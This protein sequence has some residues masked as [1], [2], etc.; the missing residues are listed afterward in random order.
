MPRG[1]KGSGKPKDP[2]EDLTTDF[3]DA[4]A[5][6]SREEIER[7]IVKVV[8]DDVDLRKAKKDDQ[9]L[10][11][12]QEAF[13]EA[14]AIYRDGFKSNK[15]KI[16]YMKRVLDDKGGVTGKVKLPEGTKVTVHATGT[17][18]EKL[19]AALGDAAE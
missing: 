14:S 6:S 2:F 16:E 13:K 8:M 10:K 3:K 9:D 17:L 18:G 19:K 15:L 4:I 11:E 7:R 1:V 5:G 12:K